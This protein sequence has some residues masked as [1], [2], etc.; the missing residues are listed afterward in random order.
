MS[1]EALSSIFLRLILLFWM[2]WLTSNLC[3]VVSKDL[4]RYRQYSEAFGNLLIFV[5][6]N[7]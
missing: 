1:V 5:P 3:C 7:L 2:T 4:K 6:Y